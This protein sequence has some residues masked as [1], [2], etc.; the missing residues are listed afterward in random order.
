MCEQEER[1]RER[2]GGRG[3]KCEGLRPWALSS[4]GP[5]LVPTKFVEVFINSAIHEVTGVPT[6]G[7]HHAGIIPLLAS[8]KCSLAILYGYSNKRRRSDNR[9]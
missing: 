4:A 2:E 9:P 5:N 8:Q 7:C 6:V 3:Q 1:Q